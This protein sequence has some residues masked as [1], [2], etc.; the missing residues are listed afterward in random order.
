MA[1]ILSKDLH[2]AGEEEHRPI[3]MPAGAPAPDV[4][5]PADEEVERSGAGA[6]GCHLVERL[7][8]CRKADMARS[9]L[10]RGLAG[11]KREH[12]IRLADP[13]RRCRCDHEHAGSQRNADGL[14]GMG[15]DRLAPDAIRRN[16]SAEIPTEQH[17]R[18]LA[19][20]TA[21]PV[22]DGP[23][24]G[25]ACRLE[26]T[27][28]SHRPTD[29]QQC[30]PRRSRRAHRSK[31]RCTEAGD[32]RCMGERFHILD[33]GRQ[34]I[35]AALKRTGRDNLRLGEMAG[36]A[37]DQGCLLSGDVPVRP[38][39]H[40]DE[41]IAV[42]TPPALPDRRAQR[43]LH[44]AVG[45]RRVDDH[46]SSTD[47]LRCVL[48]AVKHKVRPVGHQEAILEARG[49]ALGG[50]GDHDRVATALCVFLDR[51]P[52]A[53][54]RKV[55]PA[56]PAQSAG[57]EGIEQCIRLG[58]R[59]RA[60]AGE[61]RVQVLRNRTRREQTMGGVAGVDRDTHAVAFCVVSVPP[62]APLPWFTIWIAAST[63]PHRAVT[64]VLPIVAGAWQTSPPDRVT[65]SV[66]LPSA[67]ATITNWSA[68]SR[69]SVR[70]AVA[71]VGEL[72]KVPMSGSFRP[73]ARCVTG[74][75][76]VVGP[77]P[78]RASRSAGV[79]AA[80]AQPCSSGPTAIHRINAPIEATLP[81]MPR[82]RRAVN[83]GPAWARRQ[84][85]AAITAPTH[86]ATRPS[87]QSDLVSVPVPRPWI[88]P[89]GQLAYAKRCTPRHVRQPRR[90]RTRL[91]AAIAISNSN[92][93][94]PRTSH[95]GRY[96]AMKGTNASRNVSFAN[97]SMID[98]R[99]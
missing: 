93:T 3:R 8:N 40:L 4:V 13:A 97:G 41:S 5:R 2:R 72:T 71:W 91:V 44:V 75:G 45:L 27:R 68:R 6:D 87:A 60:E 29:R 69:V 12:S 66:P 61:V 73:A 78:E 77:A 17:R 79:P 25:V 52:L 46:P 22:N 63:P 37:R 62:I 47:R 42:V 32:E 48:E 64:E 58:L 53:A 50:V 30:G 74:T 19:V 83:L 57:V 92:P 99:M 16:P 43:C 98:V 76:A 51:P 81:A 7:G 82:K 23:N 28:S 18:R 36:D 65:V 1:K 80:L 35:D 10:A 56:P 15:V 39:Q 55:G 49:F 14:Q 85:S 38:D 59:T 20:D 9:A 21:G 95:R 24:G 34:V 96:D 33:E 86:T 84:T 54:R 31:P 94:T 88:T 89:T 90:C 67:L 11:E 26:D 70:V